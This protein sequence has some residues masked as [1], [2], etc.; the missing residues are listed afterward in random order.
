MNRD[1]NRDQGNGAD[2]R[3]NEGVMMGCAAARG[4]TSDSMDE[5]WDHDAQA[6][7]GFALHVRRDATREQVTPAFRPPPAC[8][9]TPA[10]AQTCT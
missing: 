10:C 2:P 1:V 9:H 6:V 4:G 8:A 7:D 5:R 3:S